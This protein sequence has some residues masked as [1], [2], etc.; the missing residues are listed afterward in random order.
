MIAQASAKASRLGCVNIDLVHAGA[1]TLTPGWLCGRVGPE[2]GPDGAEAV[3]FTYSLSLVK[4]WPGAWRAATAAA[5]SGAR[6]VVVDLRTPTGAATVLAPLAR[7]ACTLGGS[8]ITAHP[9]PWTPLERDCTDVQAW[10]LRGGHIQVRAGPLASRSPR[11]RPRPDPVATRGR[12]P[13]RT[14]Q[15][16]A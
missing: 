2:R 6:V 11:H 8:D 9:Y 14:D 3:R 10:S 7:L 13:T 5:R 16:E 15:G 12:Y 1:T 4:D